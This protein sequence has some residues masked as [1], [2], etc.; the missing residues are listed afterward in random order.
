MNLKLIFP[1]VN[2][3]QF[4]RPRQCANPQCSGKH[5]IPYQAVRKN[6]RDTVHEEV[7]A[8]R[9]RC[10][11]CGRTFRVY[12]HGVQAAHFSQRVRGVA[13]VL[14]VL[15]L[16]YGAVVLILEPLGVH[17]SK[18]SVYR[19][20]QAAAKRLPGMK[21]TEILSSYRKHSIGADLTSDKRKGEWLPIGVMV[22]PINGL[23]LSIDYLSGEDAQALQEWI[24]P[25]ADVVGAYTLVTDDVDAFKRA[26][27][28]YL[29]SFKN[30]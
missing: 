27:L 21:R 2:P 23:V 8:W 12:P 29:P 26:E 17:L 13:V 16:S 7:T 1:V 4:E 18:T 3:A 28:Q 10:L 22:D 6:I 30:F 9:Y 15:G 20:V 11:T 19:S 5:F 14:Y 25:I 24:E